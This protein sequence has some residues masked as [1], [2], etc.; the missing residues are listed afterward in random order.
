MGSPQWDVG[1]QRPLYYEV[2]TGRSFFRGR[3]PLIQPASL[4]VM[5]IPSVLLL[6]SCI[7]SSPSLWAEEPVME[8]NPNRPT[9]ANPALTTQRGLAELEWGGQQTL[10]RDGGSDFGTPTVLKL[11]LVKDLEIRLASPGWLRLAAPGVDTVS[12]LGDFNLGAQWC[13]RHNGL[14]GMDQAVQ[15]SHT[16]PTASAAKG[17]GNGAPSDGLILLFSKDMGPHHLDVNLLETWVGRTPQDGGGRIRQPAVASSL[18]RALT[19]TW[20]VTGEIYAIG[21]T[22]LGPRV[23]SNLWAVGYKVSPRL[24]LDAGLDIGLTHGAQKVSLFAGLT[25]GLARFQSP[26]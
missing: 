12:G 9:F 26:R 11:G 15:I 6:T 1:K 22:E 16:F 13:Y 25:V 8:V 7:I 19:E 18:S 4:E 2:N 23:V 10:L 3:V 14:F 24:V 17:L 21:G 20:S 5:S